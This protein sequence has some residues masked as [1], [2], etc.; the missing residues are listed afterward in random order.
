MNHPQTL[1]AKLYK[2]FPE[3]KL[4]NIKEYACCAFTLL[5]C[6]GYEPDDVEAINTVADMIESG[7][8]GKDCTVNWKDA[9]LF[10]SGR[11]VS[12]VEFKEI[13]SIKDIKE[14][15]PVRFDCNKKSHWVGVENGEVKFNSLAYSYCVE[16]G[17][18]TTMRKIIF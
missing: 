4:F 17:K 1:A 13:D 18:P 15:T 11:T 12:K 7:A 9:V 16:N 14:R 8:I 2:H 10:L 3:R 5:W 6:L